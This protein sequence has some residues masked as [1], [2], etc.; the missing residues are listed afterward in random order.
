MQ[1]TWVWFM[2]QEDPLEEGKAANSS[3]LAWEIPWTEEPDGLVYGVT[4]RRAQLSDW[5]CV[6][7]DTHTVCQPWSSDKHTH[8]HTHGMSAMTIWRMLSLSLTH[9]LCQPR[10]SDEHMRAHT[11]YVSHDD[12]M[13]SLSKVLAGAALVIQPVPVSSV[14]SQLSDRCLVWKLPMR[15]VEQDSGPS[16]RSTWQSLNSGLPRVLSREPQTNGT[17]CQ[18]C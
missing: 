1:E 2:D 6:H 14:K 13:D 7:T 3:I 15:P 9:T 16:V 11:Q 18:G 17:R 10:S 4:Q 5:V 12:L 8:I